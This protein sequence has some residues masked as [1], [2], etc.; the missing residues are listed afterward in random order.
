M[1][2]YTWDSTFVELFDRCLTRYRGGDHDFNG[3]YTEDDLAFLRTIGYK[4]RE[5][6]DFIE[7][8]GDEG[9]PSLTTA[10]MIASV[11]RDFLNVVQNGKLSKE[12]TTP[13][14]LP[15][16]DAELGGHEWLPRI[17]TKARSKLRGELHPDI[18]YSCGG[19]RNFL[20]SHDLAPA[21]FLRAVW[22]AE[23]DDEEILEWVN[24]NRGG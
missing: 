17:I 2:N 7:D 1:S 18:M 14:E 19:D 15:A 23:D 10:V 11:R 22:A 3:Y 5:L 13:D 24:E 20:R 12:E 4:P 9:E 6:F 8:F 16:R 21:D